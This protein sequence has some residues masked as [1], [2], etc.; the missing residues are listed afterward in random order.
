[1]NLLKQVAQVLRKI[2]GEKNYKNI[3]ANFL[4]S[5]LDRPFPL[6]PETPFDPQW[7]K[8]DVSKL[9]RHTPLVYIISPTQRS[10]TNFLGNV[11][12]KH[13]E[14]E[15]PCGKDLPAEQC[16][17]SYSEHI[18][19]YAYN[20]VSCWSKWVDGGEP[21]LEAHAKSMVGYM[22]EGILRYFQSFIGNDKILLFRTPDA[23][24][25]ENIYHL[26]PRATVIILIRDGRD[27]IESFSKSW[28]GDGTFKQMCKR[29]SS[30]V[31]SILEFQKQANQAG[32]K[33]QYLFVRFDHFN[34]D[35]A[36]EL[37][38]IINFLQLDE[39]RYPWNEI[40]DVP[41][42]GSSSHQTNDI[43]H[44]SPIKKTDQFN[45]NHKWL[46]WSES[47]KK[48]FKKYAGDNLIALGFATDDKW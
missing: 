10:G 11:L 39:D 32:L 31:D 23:G 45:P 33:N 22:G 18:K 28:G 27:T 1:M 34:N 24:Q 35:T 7:T 30:R 42:L 2:I 13:E 48:I 16:L 20:T 21:M 14:L 15:V 25:L 17:Y 40:D 41:I 4:F 3:R 9:N 6:F 43:V 46:N 19:A 44:W 47:K 12:S 37:K 8:Q 36:G 5:S 29:W 38:K 26:F